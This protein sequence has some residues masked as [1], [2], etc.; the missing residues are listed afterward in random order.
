M[1]SC[2]IESSLNQYLSE[3]EW[4]DALADALQALEDELID[5][6][7]K[8]VGDNLAYILFEAASKNARYQAFL[9]SELNRRID[10]ARD[11]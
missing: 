1:K 11:F 9:Q 8:A 7:K 3:L 2:P 10:D 6:V 5:G 4:Q